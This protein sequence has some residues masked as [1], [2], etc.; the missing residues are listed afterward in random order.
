MHHALGSLLFIALRCVRQPYQIISRKVIKL[1]KQD[2][3]VYFQLCPT[4]FNVV[5]TL[6][7]FVKNSAD[8]AL[9]VIYVFMH[10]RL[11]CDAGAIFNILDGGNSAAEHEIVR[12]NWSIIMED[13]ID[14]IAEGCKV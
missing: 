7:C 3:I 13:L 14:E 2:K 8:L 6:L 10:V 11:T 4:G 9:S 12:D 5:V 1:A